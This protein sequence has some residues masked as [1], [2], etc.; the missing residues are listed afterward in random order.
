MA[1]IRFIQ[2]RARNEQPVPPHLEHK[3]H[4]KSGKA[5]ADPS[6]ETCHAARAL[7]TEREHTHLEMELAIV[8][9]LP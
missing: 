6:Y 8:E 3:I 4:A 7:L 2:K 9:V 5:L 1:G